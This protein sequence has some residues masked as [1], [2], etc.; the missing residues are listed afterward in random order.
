MAT[1][2]NLDVVPAGRWVGGD[3]AFYRM[4][5]YWVE[6]SALERIR[7]GPASVDITLSPAF[8]VIRP[9]VFALITRVSI[10]RA[11]SSGL[12]AECQAAARAFR[13]KPLIGLDVARDDPQHEAGRAHQDITV[14]HL[15]QIIAAGLPAR[16]VEL[17]S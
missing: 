15:G 3:G 9:A 2:G 6:A 16:L 10:D 17:V 11:G 5:P 14:E 12:S 4:A 8:I 7:G 13:R 1:I